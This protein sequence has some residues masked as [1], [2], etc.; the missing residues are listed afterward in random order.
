MKKVIGYVSTKDLGTL[1]EQDIKNLDVINIAFGLIERHR[2]VWDS[3]GNEEYLPKIREINPDI[4]IV[5]SVGGWGA[6]GF[7]QA[8]RSEEGRAL[9]AVSA[10]SLVETYGLDGIDI[11]WEY[12]GTSLAGIGS[13]VNDKENY[14]LLLKALRESLNHMEGEKSLSVAV[15]GDVYFAL[16]TDMKAASKYLD[17][18]QLMTYDL[19]GGFQKV[20]GHHAALYHSEGNLLDVCVDKAVKAFHEAGVPMEKL[21]LGVPFIPDSGTVSKEKAAAMDS[22]WRPTALAATAETT[23]SSKPTGSERMVL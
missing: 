11:D 20:T 17:Y 2:V 12:P 14:T 1:K 6:D 10:V 18:V 9:F 7:S 16:Q 5:L 4:K 21:I 23:R 19:Q 15:G 8:A 3:C 22:E 13:H